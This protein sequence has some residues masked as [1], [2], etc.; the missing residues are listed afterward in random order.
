MIIDMIVLTKKRI[1]FFVCP[2]HVNDRKIRS[3][4]AFV[5]G[6]AEELPTIADV[7]VTL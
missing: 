2:Q 1:F 4:A 7:L 6:I 3:T 5:P